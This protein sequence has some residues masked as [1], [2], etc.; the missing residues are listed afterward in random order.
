M[1]ITAGAE[2][3]R[4][5]DWLERCLSN[6]EA[7]ADKAGER[8]AELARA[9]ARYVEHPQEVGRAALREAYGQFMACHSANFGPGC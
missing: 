4:N 3:A 2:I 6:A 1:T 5:V 9:V 8:G 7:R